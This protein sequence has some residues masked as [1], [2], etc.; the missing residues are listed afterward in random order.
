[1]ALKR[2]KTMR[3]YDEKAKPGVG[4]TVQ[5]VRE[6]GV[7]ALRRAEHGRRQLGHLEQE[8]QKDKRRG[9]RPVVYSWP[10]PCSVPGGLPVMPTMSGAFELRPSNF[11]E[12]NPLIN[13]AAW[14]LPKLLM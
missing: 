7:R 12:R 8:K 13:Q 6:V 10:A 4:D 1:M 11:F 2:Q 14:E 3:F 9:H 5:Q